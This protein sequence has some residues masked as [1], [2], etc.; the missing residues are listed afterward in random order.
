MAA[1]VAAVTSTSRRKG[2]RA[3]I[4]VRAFGLGGFKAW[5][6]QVAEL[7]RGEEIPS[8]EFSV[9]ISRV[10]GHDTRQKT[11]RIVTPLGFGALGFGASSF[12]D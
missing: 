11:K 12:S 9:L 6:F 8:P 7:Q 4:F 2:L 1:A 10:H 3:S 5:R